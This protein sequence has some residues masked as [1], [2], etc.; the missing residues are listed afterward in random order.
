MH[1]FYL[2]NPL[3]TGKT[4]EIT[5]KRVVWQAGKVLRM[6]KGDRFRIF[7]DKGVEMSAEIVDIDKRHIL[8][9]L[10]EE[11]RN[12]AESKLIVN[13]YQAIPKKPALFE[14]VVQK[15]T[16][17]G[18]SAIYPLITQRTERNRTAKFERIQNIAMEAA[19]Q[20][21]RLKV[22]FI[23]HP[24]NFESAIKDAKNA[25]IAY[26]FEDKKFISDYR[27]MIKKSKELNIFIG[28]EGGFSEKEIALAEKAGALPF[29]FGPRIL[30][31]ETAAISALSLVLLEG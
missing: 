13:L 11:I 17:I 16:E 23:H 24:V 21:G 7:N 26:E 3:I 19:E 30:R 10:V 25:L 12:D 22:P 6:W 8:A 5:D 4:L 31:T 27:D 28:P 18:V 15:A 1:R 14:I 29:T 20:S 9:N 2:E